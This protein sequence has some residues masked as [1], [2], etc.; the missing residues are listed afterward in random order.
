M[1]HRVHDLAENTIPRWA[2]HPTDRIDIRGVPHVCIDSFE[3]SHILMMF[4]DPKVNITF[5]DTEIETFRK[6]R[7]LKVT[8]FAYLHSTAVRESV[9]DAKSFADFSPG[10]V[11]KV[12]FRQSICAGVLRD[13]TKGLVTRSDQS[14]SPVIDRVYGEWLLEDIK[15]QTIDGRSGSKTKFPVLIKPAPSTLRRWLRRYEA[16]DLDILA[17]AD[18][19]GRSGNRTPRLSSTSRKLVEK[20]ARRY[21]SRLQPTK[22][23]IYRDLLGKVRRLNDLIKRRNDRQGTSIKLIEKPS[24]GTLDRAIGKLGMFNVLA[25]RQGPDYAKRKLAIV[26]GGLDVTRPLER[27]ELDE[28]QVP[29]QL[30]LENAGMWAK[31]SPAA[32]KKAIKSRLWVSTAID[33]ATRIVLAARLIRT[34]T[35]LAAVETLNAAVNDKSIAAAAAGCEYPWNQLGT[36]ES[37]STDTGSAYVKY[38][39]RAAAADL[40]TTAMLMPAGHPYLRGTQE[41]LY[42]TFEDQLLSYIS[43]RTFGN[44]VAKGDYDAEGNAVLDTEEFGRA[45]VRFIVDVYHLTPHSGLGG[46]TPLQKWIDLR[47]RYR[48]LPPPDPDTNR[49]IF[50]TP[51][52]RR[53]G[54]RGIR[55]LGL[56]YQSERLQRLR[57]EVHQKQVLVRID[58]RNLGFISVRAP[59]GWFT[60]KCQRKGFDNVPIVQWLLT[61]THLRRQNAEMSRVHEPAMLRAL[62][63]IQIFADG[64]VTRA[65]IAAPIMS[66]QD[67]DRFDRELF[68]TFRFADEGDGTVDILGLSEGETGHPAME[69]DEP[70]PTTET[71]EDTVVD[72][73][74]YGNPDISSNDQNFFVED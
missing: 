70:A 9:T 30:I 39:F 43:G 47:K 24:R 17:L 22:A 10:A 74:I 45:L 69:G 62:R 54:N 68:K 46:M 32:R 5:T 44:V 49:H 48:V 67:F 4:D 8:K 61:A 26:L 13:E 12:F 28:W 71:V 36:P 65:G 34:P 50:G 51:L 63:D 57:D 21:L 52:N 60:V 72:E 6:Q 25:A 3:N 53:I 41:R 35:G 58:P 73:P 40:G 42:K 37:I 23:Q 55:I 7:Q 59:S 15:A 33:C 20:Y 11:R 38:E 14:L 2:F 56:H 27:V 66:W 18:N 64:A 16:C 31:L 29:L 19:Y 1:A